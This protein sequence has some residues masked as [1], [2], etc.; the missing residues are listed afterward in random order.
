MSQSTRTPF[1][2]VNLTS[3]YFNIV[4]LLLLVG[5]SFQEHLYFV[6]LF[7]SVKFASRFHSN[8]KPGIFWG[9]WASSHCRTHIILGL[10]SHTKRLRLCSHWTT[11]TFRTLLRCCFRNNYL[12][13]WT[14]SHSVDWIWYRTCDVQCTWTAS[15]NAP[16]V[17]S[18]TSTSVGVNTA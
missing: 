8:V 1:F 12:S 15:V 3:K 17:T 18:L 5:V 2:I 7:R 9:H 11:M 4:N 13:V 16:L 14:S 10:L 6:V